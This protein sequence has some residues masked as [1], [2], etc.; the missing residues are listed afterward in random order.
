LGH[1]LGTAEALGAAGRALVFLGRISEG[2]EILHEALSTARAL[3]ARKLVVW[4]LISLGTARH[5]SGDLL[6]SR[7]FLHEALANAKES[8]AEELA[9]QI[10]SNLAEARFRAG[11]AQSAL[12]LGAE[13]LAAMRALNFARHLA[14]TTCNMAAYCITLSRY[15]EG[16]QHA[17]EA[18]TLC[19]DQQFDVVLVWA[20][21]HLAAVEA[22]R[23]P[24]GVLLWDAPDRRRSA[25]LLGYVDARLNALEARR[26]VAETQVY[27][28]MVPAL[29][30]ALG[31]EQLATLMDEGRKWTEDRAVSKALLV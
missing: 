25:R 24:E 12:Q 19:R 22:L 4:V 26:E 18:L 27:D 11:D 2:D 10:A 23:P 3:G 16:R 29:R 21:Q 13:A 14:V 8:G 9:A 15:D 31:E 1:P 6:E 28:A 7:A 20:L 30:E 5:F 17:R